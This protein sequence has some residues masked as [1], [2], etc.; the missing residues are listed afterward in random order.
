MKEIICP[1]C[2]KAITINESDYNDLLNQIKNHEIE[3]R[4]KEREA[5]ILSAKKAEEL[6]TAQEEREKRKALE[7]EILILKNA[8]NSKDQE[9]ELALTKAKEENSAKIQE[10]TFKLNGEEERRKMAVLEATSSYEKELSTRDNQILSLTNELKEKDKEQDEKLKEQ[11]KNFNFI[12]KSKDEQIEQ[13]KDMKAKLSTKMVGEELEQHCLNEFN[14]LRMGAFPNAYFDKDNDAADGS[15]GDFIFRDYDDGQ[16]YISIMFEMKNEMDETSTKHKNEDFFKKLD[17]DRTAK[18]CEYAVLVSLLESDSDY[19]NQGIVDVSYLY[20]KMYVI[21]PQF[22]I[23]LITLLRNAAK[24]TVETKKELVAYQQEHIDI[25]NFESKLLD[26][27]EGFA[28]NYQNAQSKFEAAIKSIDKSISDLQKTKEA[29][30]S[31]ENQLRLA[32]DK[33]QSVTIRR[34]THGNPTMARKFKE[35]KE[36]DE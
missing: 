6:A 25:T 21:R 18:K 15:K 23:P 13:Y 20:D 19:Y 8:L 17:K 29:L 7:E 32:N 34:L 35:L 31:S 9:K 28:K 2:G 16:E 3:D 1:H 26:F 27:Q 33:A 11:E 4:V 24:K 5:V 22:F 12:L 14:K 36:D 10:L 30:L